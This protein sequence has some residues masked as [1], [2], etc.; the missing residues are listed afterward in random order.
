M[1]TRIRDTCRIFTKQWQREQELAEEIRKWD[2]RRLANSTKAKYGIV[3]H[4][5]SED[6]RPLSGHEF[7]SGFSWTFITL[8]PEVL[9]VVDVT[10]A[11][12]ATRSRI[13]L[14]RRALG[15]WVGVEAGYVVELRAGGRVFLKASH[16]QGTLEFDKHLHSNLKETMPHLRHDLPGERRYIR[17]RLKEIGL[18]TVTSSMPSSTDNTG[19]DPSVKMPQF[20][21]NSSKLATIHCALSFLFFASSKGMTYRAAR[22]SGP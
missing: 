20:F 11:G 2:T 17:D 10:G 1:P 13:Q 16:V 14:Y 4:A 22:S 6:G 12:S 8:I 21:L 7:Q 15:V 19:R 3:V 18:R 5:W 9:S